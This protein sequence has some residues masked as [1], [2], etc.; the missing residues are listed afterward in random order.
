ML[1][2]IEL[3]QYIALLQNKMQEVSFLVSA[4]ISNNAEKQKLTVAATL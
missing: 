2:V 3:V 4:D 1:P